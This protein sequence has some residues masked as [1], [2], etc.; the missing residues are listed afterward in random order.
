MKNKTYFLTGLFLLFALGALIA[1]SSC[2][3]DA[4]TLQPAIQEIDEQKAGTAEGEN[5]D[6]VRFVPAEDL[7]RIAGL[8]KR[9]SR[10]KRVVKATAYNALASQTD[11][12]PLICAWG[13]R[14]RPGIIAV[15]RDLERLGLTRGQEVHVEG[16]GKRVVMDRMHKRKENQ[17]DIFMNSYEAA[18]NFGV[19]ELVISWEAD[20]ETEKERSG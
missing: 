5:R 18:V 16:L 20:P 17:I 19:Q 3:R 14:I 10:F 4:F 6:V 8:S 11:S 2:L 1:C 15:S 13:D 9:A 7:A 12:T